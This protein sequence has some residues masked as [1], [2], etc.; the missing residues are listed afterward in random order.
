MSNKKQ[1]HVVPNRER[2]GWDVVKPHAERASAHCDSKQEAF[3]RGRVIA[4]N[5][6]GELV[7]HNKNGQISER[8]SYGN[9]P[10]PP[11]DRK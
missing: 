1:V 4:Q 9:D 3:E 8:R 10:C 7:S 2:G 5:E 6:G 11:K